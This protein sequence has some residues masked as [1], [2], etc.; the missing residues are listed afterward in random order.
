MKLVPG[1]TYSETITNKNVV[2]RKRRRWGSKASKSYVNDI[3]I[4]FLNACGIS[5]KIHELNNHITKD[6]VAIICM[7]ETFLKTDN[8]PPKPNKNYSWVGKCRKN[9]KGKGGIG[10]C[11]NVDTPLLDANLLNSKNDLHER[12]LV[13]TRLGGIKTAVGVVYFPNDGLNKIV[14]K[15]NNKITELRTILQRESQNS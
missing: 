13:L 12:V 2:K 4:D 6:N 10:M 15:G 11:L 1:G 3:K 8:K 5:N 9:S 14:N 7:V